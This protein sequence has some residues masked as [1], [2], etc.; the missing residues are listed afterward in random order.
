MLPTHRSAI[1]TNKFPTMNL[2]ACATYKLQ[3]DVPQN[4]DISRLQ[5]IL[6]ITKGNIES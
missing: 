3:V 1:L 6:K 5:H 2:S 4:R